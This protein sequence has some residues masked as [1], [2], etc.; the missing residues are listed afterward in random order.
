MLFECLSVLSLLDLENQRFD[1]RQIHLHLDECQHLPRIQ[2][3]REHHLVVLL[4]YIH[5]TERQVKGV[6]CCL[7]VSG[8]SE[9]AD[10]LITV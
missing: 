8:R 9:L 1:T 5:H 4:D 7:P 6:H 2:Q 3:S 10:I